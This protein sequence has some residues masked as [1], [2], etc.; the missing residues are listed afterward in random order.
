MTI[1]RETFTELLHSMMFAFAQSQLSLPQTASVVWACAQPTTI[2]ETI[3]MTEEVRAALNDWSEMDK[4]MLIA[5]ECVQMTF[6]CVNIHGPCKK[7]KHTVHMTRV[8]GSMDWEPE[9]V[10]SVHDFSEVIMQ[11]TMSH[12]PDPAQGKLVS[13]RKGRYNDLIGAFRD[14]FLEQP[15]NTID[16]EIDE[17][18]AELDKLFPSAPSTPTEKGGSDDS[19]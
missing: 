11:A 15:E 6:L 5:V 13:N 10:S 12:H 14:M 3:D 18:R 2:E 7:E 4:G 1:E 8:I 16:K 17:F 19:P 9:N